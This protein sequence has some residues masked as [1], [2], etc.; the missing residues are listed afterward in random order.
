MKTRFVFEGE[1]VVHANSKDQ[2]KMFVK[3]HCGLVLGSNIH[4][5]LKYE[6]IHGWNFQ[7]HPEKK[8]LTIKL[9]NR[10]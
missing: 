7:M 4:T 5:T 2:A 3:D 8:I 9:S 1:F 10:C 6:E